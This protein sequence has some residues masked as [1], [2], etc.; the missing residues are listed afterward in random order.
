LI[1]LLLRDFCETASEL[2]VTNPL[3]L[4]EKSQQG[5]NLLPWQSV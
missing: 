2:P 3:R 5:A 4:L 1:H